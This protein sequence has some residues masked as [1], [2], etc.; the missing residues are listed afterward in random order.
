[1]CSL[2]VTFSNSAFP[3][4]RID[5]R[6]SDQGAIWSTNWYKSPSG[7]RCG[8]PRLDHRSVPVQAAAVINASASIHAKRVGP[9]ICAIPGA[10]QGERSLKVQDSRRFARGKS[11]LNYVERLF[12]QHAR[13]LFARRLCPRLLL[14][15]TMRAICACMRM[16][17]VRYDATCMREPCRISPAIKA[18]R[19]RKLIARY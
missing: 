9:W 15:C 8:W 7:P 16:V 6:P 10:H 14:R 4:L 3:G 11:C 1:M 13:G 17:M 18:E 2:S 5:A 12:F 19:E